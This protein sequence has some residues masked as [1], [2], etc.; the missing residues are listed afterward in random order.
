MPR[1]LSLFLI[2]VYFF[3]FYF[4]LCFVS[5]SHPAT[6]AVRYLQTFEAALFWKKSS[7]N[8]KKK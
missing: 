7:Q 4:M 3:C 8:V 1:Y 5:S 6:N 2:L